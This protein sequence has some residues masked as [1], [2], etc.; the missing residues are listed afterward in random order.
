MHHIWLVMAKNIF[1]S[2]CVD[3]SIKHKTVK[4]LDYNRWKPSWPG[5]LAM[6]GCCFLDTTP[7]LQSVRKHGL[8][9]IKI[10][11]ALQKMVYTGLGNKYLQKIHLTKG[12]YLTCGKNSKT[13]QE[14]NK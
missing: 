14:E 2:G 12:C 3:L 9:F 6:D 11:T 10:K 8:D 5:P 1:L 4:F 7:K 13:Q